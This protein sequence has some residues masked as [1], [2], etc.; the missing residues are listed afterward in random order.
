MKL[1]RFAVSGLLTAALV[2]GG[3]VSAPLA[4]AEETGAAERYLVTLKDSAAKGSS[5]EIFASAADQLVVGMKSKNIKVEKVF[6]NLGVITADMTA[7]QAQ[8]LA[9]QS[10]VY[11]VEKDPVLVADAVQYNAAWHL[12]RL[13]QS[14]F[15]YSTRDGKYNYVNNG[16]GVTAY[17][18]DSGVD[19]N[20]PDIKG[21]VSSSSQDFVR[22]GYGTKGCHWHGTGVSTSLA[23]TK[24]G[25]A[26]GATIVSLRTGNC[27]GMNLGSAIVEAIDYVDRYAKKPS[28]VNMS[29]S[30]V[31][32]PSPAMDT[33]VKRIYNKGI[34]VV[35]SAGNANKDAC[36]ASPA[37]VPEL[38]TV[39]AS[40]PY[41]R[42]ASFTSYGSCVDLYAPGTEIQIHDSTTYAKVQG[43]S[44]SAPLTAGAVAQYLQNHPTASPA[45]VQSVLINTSFKN[46]VKYNKTATP[47]RMLNS[48]AMSNQ[49]QLPAP[50]PVS[51]KVDHA[52]TKVIGFI[53]NVWGTVPAGTTSAW[54]EVWTGTTWARSQTRTPNANG[55]VAIPLTYGMD[56]VGTYRYRV[57]ASVAGQLKYTAEFNFQRTELYVNSAGTKKINEVTNMW[58]TVPTAANRRAWTEVYLNGRW[59]QSQVRTANANGYVVIPLTYGSNVPGTY[60]FRAVFNTPYG[61]VIS[62]PFTLT[63][64]R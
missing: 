13:D 64:V 22:D 9:K 2:V 32:G 52:G 7:A 11:A 15:N 14:A 42:P 19:P 31:D 58:G 26:K 53:S 10:S 20:W 41:D 63:R 28:V 23:G 21:R 36:N 16:K 59:V 51:W 46:V 1:S 54:T 43:T 27:T 25:T 60:R 57:V 3:G 61:N 48:Y 35:V 38:I 5:G 4:Q 12:D 62:E 34:P 55:F 8:A 44:F 39:A 56:K 30:T 17:V 49:Y 40:D 45:T 50:K 47:N 33:L 37:R 6:S 18:I 24:Y 29:M